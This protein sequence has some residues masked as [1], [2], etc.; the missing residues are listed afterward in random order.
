MEEVRELFQISNRALVSKAIE[1]LFYEEIIKIEV[2][3]DNLLNLK[4]GENIN[5]FFK[6][7]F[8][9]F[10]SIWIDEKSIK[11]FKNNIEQEI[12]ARDFF[13]ETQRNTQMTDETLA[14]FLEEMNQTLYCDCVIL[15]RNRQIK[16]EEVL[17]MSFLEIN[18]VL[19]G[20][21][22]LILNKGRLGWGVSDL[23]EYSPENA[24][25]FK[26]IWLAGL[27]KSM[28]IGEVN[29]Q[30]E[31][32]LNQMISK[33]ELQSIKEKLG[34]NISKYYIFPVHPWQ[35]DRFIRIQYAQEIAYDQLIYLGV[36]GDFYTP[37]TSI[38]TL[39]NFDQPK[40]LDIKLSLSILNTSSVRGISSKTI[41]V[42]HQISNLIKS[43]IENDQLLTEKNLISLSEVCAVN[44]PLET[45][46]QIEKL[47]YR[48][49][50]LLGCIWRESVDSKLIDKEVAFP[51]A[52]LFHKHN[53]HYLIKDIVE[54]SG[55]SPIFWIKNYFNIVVIPL[56][57]LQLKYG[58]GLVAHGQNTIVKMKNFNVTALIIKD[59]HGDLRISSDS[60]FTNHEIANFV[61]ILPGE[62]LIHDLITGHLVTALRYLARAFYESFSMSDEIFFGL[63]GD[64]VKDYTEQIKLDFKMDSKVSMLRESIEKLLVN[65]VRFVAGYNDTRIR[66]KPILGRNMSNPLRRGFNEY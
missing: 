35:W 48:Y 8:A 33:K 52:A 50:E 53:D 49:K 32:F 18:S 43:I 31:N 65:K 7:V 58:I 55:V 62:Y 6:A 36:Y 27:R 20:H 60:V 29:P 15:E 51:V 34:N 12:L 56:Y 22:K 30:D 40:K 57:H 61:E 5:Y 26:L 39:S 44:M 11:K 2:Y 47:Q 25:A 9:S 66:L 63:L 17:K 41:G 42:G 59:F 46:D 3:E 64:V 24:N 38:R 4:C 23:E 10:D 14:Q 13:I 1:E 54:K 21:P 45:F 19:N 28:T 16:R 37:Q